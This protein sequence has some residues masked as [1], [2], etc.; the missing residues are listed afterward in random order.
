VIYFFKTNDNRICEVE[1]HMS[2]SE[3][4]LLNANNTYRLSWDASDM[5]LYD[6]NKQLI[7]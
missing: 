4:K 7:S 5:L 1:D 2:L 3:P 6:E